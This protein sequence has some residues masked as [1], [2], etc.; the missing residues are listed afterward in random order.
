MGAENVSIRGKRILFLAPA[1][2]GYELKI[3]HKMEDMG[4]IVDFYDVRS[5]TSAIERALLKIS[6]NIF[7][8]KTNKYYGEILK[9]NHEKDYD[10]I[11]IDR[12]SV[13]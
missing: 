1:F 7:V 10:Y 6:P 12:K 11:F 8:R 3:K 2:F 9:K 13:V 5:V 4:A